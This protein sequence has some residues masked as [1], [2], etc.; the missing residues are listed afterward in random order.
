MKPLLSILLFA[1]FFLM[2]TFIPA[3][4]AIPVKMADLVQIYGKPK[5]A[6]QG[7]S[8]FS[9]NDVVITAHPQYMTLATVVFTSAHSFSELEIPAL[10]KPLAAGEEWKKKGNNTWVLDKAKCMAVWDGAGKI[11]VQ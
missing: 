7:G 4:A 2:V 1:A 6:K 9:V 5:H 8:E 10:L 3:S 11:T